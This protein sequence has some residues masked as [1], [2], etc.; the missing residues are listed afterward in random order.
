LAGHLQ[1]SAQRL[2]RKADARLAGGKNDARTT[3][4]QKIDDHKITLG[5]P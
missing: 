3:N 2:S 1:A 4:D 5:G